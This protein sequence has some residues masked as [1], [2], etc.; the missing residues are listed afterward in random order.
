MQQLFER[1]YRQAEQGLHVRIGLGAGESTVKDGDYFGMPSIEAARLCAQAPIGR[2][3]RLGAGQ[4]ARGPLRGS[5]VRV[6]RRARAEGL[7]RAGGGVLGVLGAA[8]RGGG[9][10]RRLAAARRAALGAAGL[11]RRARR[12][13]RRARGGDERSPARGSARWCCS[14]A[15][16]G[17]ARRGLRATAAHRAHAEGFAV[18]WGA[19]SEELAVPYEPWI[20]VCSQLVEHAPQELLAASRRASWRRARSPGAQPG[21]RVSE[22]ARAAVL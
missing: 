19:C 13:A 17:S 6:R 1:R 8:R 21:R 22:A 20:E 18:C 12:G 4:D 15:S 11:V 3:P 5:R 10:R 14:R 9:R 7:S 16:R 2:D